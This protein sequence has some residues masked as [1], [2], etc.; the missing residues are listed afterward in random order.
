MAKTT[1]DNASPRERFAWEIF[2]KD[3]ANPKKVQEPQEKSTYAEKEPHV[4]EQ[5]KVSGNICKGRFFYGDGNKQSV[6]AE[7]YALNAWHYLGHSSCPGDRK[8]YDSSKLECYR[9]YSAKYKPN[10]YQKF[11]R[12]KI[13]LANVVKNLTKLK[14]LDAKNYLLRAQSAHENSGQVGQ[15]F[16]Y[17]WQAHHVLPWNCFI[18]VFTQID[19]AVIRRSDYDINSGE[20]IIFLPEYSDDTKHHKLPFHSSNHGKYNQSVISQFKG[21]KRAINKKRKNKEP[22]EAIAIA[23]EKELHNLENVFFRKVKNY[24]EKRLD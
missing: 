7:Y 2:K 13:D 23:I 18:S 20:N 3:S 21:L 9:F 24:G 15:D 10:F 5:K 1:Q 8:I 14:S 11:P 17:T 19:I 12:N 6:G 4:S 16:P 22:H